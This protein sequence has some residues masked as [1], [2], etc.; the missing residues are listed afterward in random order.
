MRSAL[1]RQTQPPLYGHKI[2]A[3]VV[4]SANIHHLLRSCSLEKALIKEAWFLL[5]GLLNFQLNFSLQQGLR[6][7]LLLHQTCDQKRRVCKHLR[8]SFKKTSAWGTLTQPFVVS[9]KTRHWCLQSES[10]HE[11]ASSSVF[12]C[13]DH[14]KAGKKRRKKKT[15]SG[16]RW[17]NETNWSA[18]ISKNEARSPERKRW[19]MTASRLASWKLTRPGRTAQIRLLNDSKSDRLQMQTFAYE[20][21]KMSFNGSQADCLLFIS[22]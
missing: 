4:A 22:I 21:A 13:A 14:K 8:C 12:G 1:C 3:A 7:R 6:L 10:E 5:M 2:W 9:R 18:S 17:R 16:K 11:A 15:E 19:L 20:S